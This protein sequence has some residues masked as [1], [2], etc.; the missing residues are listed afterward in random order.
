MIGRPRLRMQFGPTTFGGYQHWNSLEFAGLEELTGP[1][2][3]R[4]WVSLVAEIVVITEP[5]SD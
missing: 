2:A 4:I 1:T 3:Q 5:E